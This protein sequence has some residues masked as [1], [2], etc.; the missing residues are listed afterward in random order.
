MNE[1]TNE[2]ILVEY[3]LT[4][5]NE[6]DTENIDNYK[7]LVNIIYN[8]LYL[9]KE[10]NPKVNEAI[11]ILLKNIYQKLDPYSKEYF[12]IKEELFTHYLQGWM[13]DKK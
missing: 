7:S 6:F 12:N 3:I 11:V 9:L 8:N 13:Q 5:N 2:D 1:K 10:E 4:L